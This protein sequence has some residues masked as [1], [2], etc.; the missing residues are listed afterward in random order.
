MSMTSP[1]SI[2]AQHFAPS[3]SA[4][5]QRRGGQIAIMRWCAWIRLIEP[6]NS[7]EPSNTVVEAGVSIEAHN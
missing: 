3:A 6:G 5:P 1:T 2:V 4:I 7:Q